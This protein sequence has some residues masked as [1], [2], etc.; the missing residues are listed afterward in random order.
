MRAEFAGDFEVSCA[1][2]LEPVAQPI[3]DQVDLIFRPVGAD[4]GSPERAISTADTEI[5]Y[6]QEGG[7]ALEDVLRE[8]VLI[9]LPAKTLCRQDCKGLCPGC[10]KNLNA[11][12]CICESA[13]TDARWSAL[14]DLRNRIKS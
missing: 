10:G 11:E 6:Y 12:A 3:R 14:A 2:C 5:G 4:A 13:P 9:S 7:L 1:R 8:Q